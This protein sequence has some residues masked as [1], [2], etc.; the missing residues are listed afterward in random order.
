MHNVL[1][2]H[3]LNSW[4]R[5]RS[6]LVAVWLFSCVLLQTM[7]WM[8]TLYHSLVQWYRHHYFICDMV[9]LLTA[10]L[11]YDRQQNA[12]DKNNLDFY[13]EKVWKYLVEPGGKKF[14]PFITPCSFFWTAKKKNYFSSAHFIFLSSFYS[15]LSSRKWFFP[16]YLQVEEKLSKVLLLLLFRCYGLCGVW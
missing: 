11:E 4:L 1:P 15:T 5:P 14:R 12:R 3:I 8:P 6:W 10:L 13:H 2:V 16:F 9:I 7:P